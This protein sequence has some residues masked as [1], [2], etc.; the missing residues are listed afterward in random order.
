[1]INKRFS[2]QFSLPKCAR[3]DISKRLD[4]FVTPRDSFFSISSINS[5]KL[6]TQPLPTN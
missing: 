6:T 5:G 1:M 2:F 3:S 4:Q